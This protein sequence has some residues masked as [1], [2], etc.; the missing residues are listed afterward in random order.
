ML[1]QNQALKI[2]KL[3]F[4]KGSY[5]YAG[6]IAAMAGNLQVVN[7]GKTNFTIIEKLTG[8]NFGEWKRK[9]DAQAKIISLATCPNHIFSEL[10]QLLIWRENFPLVVREVENRANELKIIIN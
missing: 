5:Y 1:S 8:K 4:E 10:L 7:K 3:Q 9:K 2:A 6:S